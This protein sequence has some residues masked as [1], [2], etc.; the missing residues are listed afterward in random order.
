MPDGASSDGSHTLGSAT[1]TEKPLEVLD[2][3]FLPI[4]KHLQYY[5]SNPPTFNL[6]LNIL[7]GVGGTFGG[8]VPNLVL[9][10]LFC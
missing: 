5:A 6:A 1:E 9:F 8:S 3:N 7:F 10:E 2:F 4:P